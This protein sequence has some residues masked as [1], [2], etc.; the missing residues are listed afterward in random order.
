M[1]TKK[2]AKKKKLR[3][4]VWED[5]LTDYTSG[6]MFALAYSVK[7]ARKL[8]TKDVHASSQVHED[9]KQEPTVVSRPQG[10]KVWGGG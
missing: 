8:I 2:A 3:L 7:H 5:V 1:D 9:I 10:F 6:V 4:Y